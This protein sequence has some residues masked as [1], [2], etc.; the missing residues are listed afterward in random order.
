MMLFDRYDAGKQ[1]AAKLTQYTDTDA[2]VL[3]LPRGGVL[4]GYEIAKALRVPLD[5]VITRKI[6]HPLDEEVAVCA[7]T[8]DGKRV[9]EDED[10]LGL[11]KKWLQS[12]SAIAMGEIRRRRQVF[13][14][15]EQQSLTNRTVIVTDDGVATGLTM[16]AALM[17]IRSHRPRKIILAVPVCPRIV[18]RELSLLVDEVVLLSDDPQFRGAVGA[19]YTY[20]PEVFDKEVITCLKRVNVMESRV[21]AQRSS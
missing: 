7:M 18:L 13:G 19:Y 2:V 21:S 14:I 16:K 3:A 11:D 4:V 6:G 15:A 8:E 10:L 12:E 9:C 17:S 5:I 1:L 20:F